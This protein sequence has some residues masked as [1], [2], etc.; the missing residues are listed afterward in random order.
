MFD[1]DVGRGE[2]NACSQNGAGKVDHDPRLSQAFIPTTPARS[3]SRKGRADG[4]GDAA[5][6]FIHQDSAVEFTDRGGERRAAGG[7]P[8]GEAA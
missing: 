5:D 3:A 8:R 2:V 4:R 7:I 1:V 6:S